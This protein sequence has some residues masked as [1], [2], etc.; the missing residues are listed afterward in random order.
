MSKLI[1]LTQGYYTLVDDSD[2]DWLNQYKWQL[3]TNGYA[4]HYRLGMMHRA[5]MQPDQPYTIAVVDHINNIT[6]DNRRCNLRVV[7]VVVNVKNRIRV[8]TIGSHVSHARQITREG[9]PNPYP[10]DF[11]K[12]TPEVQQAIMA[13]RKEIADRERVANLDM[14]LQIMLSDSEQRQLNGYS[15]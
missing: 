7:P 14:L 11:R 3:A 2:Y 8:S 4:L 9:Y 6:N 1:P 10:E 13:C 5:I 15:F 12:C